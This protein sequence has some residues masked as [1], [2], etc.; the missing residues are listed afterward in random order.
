MEDSASW[1]VRQKQ[2]MTT[3]TP[4]N[5]SL[6]SEYSCPSGACST[7]PPAHPLAQEGFDGAPT[8]DIGPLQWEGVMAAA[9]ATFILLT[10]LMQK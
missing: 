5:P 6:P 4:A 1:H 7:P 10:R 8:T 3:F 2:K 9:V